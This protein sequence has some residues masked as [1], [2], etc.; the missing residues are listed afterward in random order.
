MAQT[1]NAIETNAKSNEQANNS[2]KRKITVNIENEWDTNAY[3]Q[4][5]KKYD[6]KIHKTTQKINNMKLINSLIQSAPEKKENVSNDNDVS[7][8]SNKNAMYN[9]ISTEHF[10]FVIIHL[11]QAHNQIFDKNDIVTT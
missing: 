6:I 11:I 3:H 9:M 1:F 4:R 2:Q 8:S 7:T 5:T 10:L